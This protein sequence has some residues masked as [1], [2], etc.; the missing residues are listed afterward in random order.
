MK[1]W[2]HEAQ[3]WLSDHLLDVILQQPT[4]GAVGRAYDRWR[5]CH[6][7]HSNCFVEL[8]WLH[9]AGYEVCAALAVKASLPDPLELFLQQS[10]GVR[11]L[12]HL[13]EQHQIRVDARGRQGQ[14]Q[15]LIGDG[16]LAVSS[17]NCE[18]GE[19]GGR[20]SEK[21]ADRGRKVRG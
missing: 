2:M 15:A 20:E 9:R 1:M 5:A 18:V 3:P 21:R 13:A 6:V 16:Q 14:R 10:V 4:E 8:R 12:A 7:H 17:C 11:E 19:R